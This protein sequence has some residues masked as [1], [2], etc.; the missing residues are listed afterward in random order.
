MKIT[1]SQWERE[2]QKRQGQ[3]DF[4]ISSDIVIEMKKNKV[5]K[6]RNSG[7]L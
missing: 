2:R 3:Y 5:D 6:R 1:S 4:I 7:C